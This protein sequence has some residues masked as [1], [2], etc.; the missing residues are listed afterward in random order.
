LCSVVLRR[1]ALGAL[2]HD[3]AIGEKIRAGTGARAITVLSA[4]LAQLR[5]IAPRRL[6]IFTPYVEDLTL[7]I[8][9]SLAEGGYAPVRAGGIGIRENLDIGRNTPEEITDFVA[10][11]IEGCA[12]D[13]AF[14]SCTNWQA[15]EAIE[16]LRSS[17][18]IPIV[19]SNQAAI[20]AVRAMRIQAAK[21]PEHGFGAA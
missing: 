7:S 14:L 10:G 5:R 15:I 11:Q 13:C 18:R 16:P 17:L 9:S 3:D 4:V 6:A 20:E 8:A 1:G 12:A 19:T 21:K 2:A